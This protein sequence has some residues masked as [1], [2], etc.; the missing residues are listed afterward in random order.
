[1]TDVR[2]TPEASV[3][4][5]LPIA[6][7]WSFPVGETIVAARARDSSGTAGPVAEM[8]VRVLE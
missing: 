5:C 7:T 1:M 4:F 2:L 8:V 3:Q 6:R